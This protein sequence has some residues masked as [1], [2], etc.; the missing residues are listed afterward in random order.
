MVGESTISK[1]TADSPGAKPT[2]MACMS[3]GGS[4]PVDGSARLVTCQYCD[5]NNYLPDGLW[6]ALHPA[7][8]RETWYVV[9][10]EEAAK[11]DGRP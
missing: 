1:T 2:V 9:F 3:C 8:K 10:D 7:A 5:A 11:L 4:L 6:L